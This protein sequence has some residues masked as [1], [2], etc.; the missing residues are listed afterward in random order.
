E[1][2]RERLLVEGEERRAHARLGCGEEGRVAPLRQEPA[3]LVGDREEALEVLLLLGAP[4][5]GEKVD[6]LDEQPRLTLALLA[7]AL[8]ETAKAGDEPVV[9][10][11][12]ERAARDLADPRRLDDEDAG[13]SLREA[14]VP[15]DHVLGDEPVLGRAPRHHGG[16]PRARARRD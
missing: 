11:P 14:A 10:D 7:H 3:V 16:H 13:T 12:Q 6:D 8:D 15:V 5:Y 2:A 9:P 4:A 1:D